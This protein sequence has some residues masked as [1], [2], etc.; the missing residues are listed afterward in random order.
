MAFPSSPSIGQEYDESGVRFYWDGTVW[1]VK[2][3]IGPAGPPGQVGVQGTQGIQGQSITG[4]QGIQGI[5]GP[6]GSG[7][8]DMLK[9]EN[10]SGLANYTTARSNL[11]LGTAATVN[12]GTSGATIPLLNG[13][14]TWSGT[15]TFSVSANLNGTSGV[16]HY[17]TFR[18]GGLLRWAAG[19]NATAEAGSESGS[20]YSI[21]RYNDAGT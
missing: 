1:R 9:S 3:H 14:N 7:V 2:G 20:A 11:G 16:G 21:Y 15:Q 5:Q 19:K 10:L 4:A 12:T 8:G 6:S 17:H 13:T 18:T